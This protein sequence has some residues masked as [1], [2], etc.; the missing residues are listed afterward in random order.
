MLESL[1][2][3]L[4]ASAAPLPAASGE[5]VDGRLKLASI[6]EVWTGSPALSGIWMGLVALMLTALGV[7]SELISYP[8]R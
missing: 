5:A 8:C 3:N 2:S 6:C 7:P 1:G 4:E